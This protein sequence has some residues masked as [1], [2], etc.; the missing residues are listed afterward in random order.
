[1]PDYSL[2]C[3]ELYKEV[4]TLLWR[5]DPR[6]MVAEL[7]HLYRFHAE[8][9]GYPSW[10]PDFRQT[11]LR[12]W[13]DRK[14]L[15]ATGVWRQ[16]K[17]PCFDEINE[18]LI[19]DGVAV[20]R[21][22]AMYRTPESL[23]DDRGLAE[24]VR[25]YER[26]IREA[27]NRAVPT[28]HPLAGLA[29]M[30]K[31]ESSMRILT[32]SSVAQMDG[33][34][35]FHPQHSDRD[36]WNTFLGRNTLGDMEQMDHTVAEGLFLRL[37]RMLTGMLDDRCIFTTCSGFAG[38]GVM[39]IEVGDVVTLLFGASGPVILRPYHGFSRLVGCAY[40]S[41]LM[42]N[43]MLDAVLNRGLITEQQFVIR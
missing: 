13:Q 30:K 9:N 4:G 23:P 39:G 41:G 15:Q 32:R 25:R 18:R 1:M 35:R 22:D 8:D 3:M 29:T 26:I 11:K 7:I 19:L 17:L 43:K 37:R 12:A 16:L 27:Q 6:D 34:E 14:A 42:E 33:D 24:L 38:I 28:S 10:V 2:D 36:I 21:V 5:E 31:A 20:D 40:V